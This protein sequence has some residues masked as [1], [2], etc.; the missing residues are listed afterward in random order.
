MQYAF[1]IQHL[2]RQ[3][4]RKECFIEHHVAKGYDPKKFVFY[5]SRDG[6]DYDD[7]EVMRGEMLECYPELNPP[8]V[9]GRGEFGCLWGQIEMVDTFSEGLLP[10][11]EYVWYVQDDNFL[12]LPVDH[13]ER[14]LEAFVARD[15]DFCC[16]RTAYLHHTAP[17]Y[18]I[19]PTFTL[20]GLGFCEGWRG[21]GDSGVL[22]NRRAA[23]L[24][25]GEM[26]KKRIFM[27]SI[28]EGDTPM[29]G[30]KGFYTNCDKPHRAEYHHPNAICS[31]GENES[32]RERLNQ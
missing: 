22:M 11:A 17:P 10:D 4:E 2:L 31:F 7:L 6:A 3:T 19:P 30:E 15:P 29:A 20:E 1:F 18:N 25:R 23:R 16:W 24:I 27:G 9:V 8:Q 26:L 13:F 21:Y 14:I 5:S 32:E 28:N 12:N